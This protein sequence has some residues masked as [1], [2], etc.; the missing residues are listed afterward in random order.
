MCRLSVKRHK[1]D[2]KQ[3]EVLFGNGLALG[4]ALGKKVVVC[5]ARKKWA[6]LIFTT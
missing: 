3:D 5:A 6:V 1:G 2:T 4:T